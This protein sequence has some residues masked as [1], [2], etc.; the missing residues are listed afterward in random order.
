LKCLEDNWISSKGK[1]IKKFEDSFKKK[2]GYKYSCVT[3]NGTTALH[4][5]LLALNIKAKDEK[6]NKKI[7]ELSNYNKKKLGKSLFKL[8]NQII[9]DKD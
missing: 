1:F 2:F 6:N 7:I 9:N 8:I 3:T 5:S 4:L